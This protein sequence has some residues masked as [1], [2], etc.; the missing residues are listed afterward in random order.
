MEPGQFDEP[1]GIA[2]DQAGLVYVADTWNQRIQVFQPD[3]QGQYSP[4]RSWDLQAWYG[5]SLENKPY[6]TVDTRA[7]V[8]LRSGRLSHP[9]VHTA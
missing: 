7:P 6:L 9:A 5:Q 4:L 1:V 2:V 8:R 3:D